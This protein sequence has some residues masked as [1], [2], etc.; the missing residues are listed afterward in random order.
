MNVDTDRNLYMCLIVGQQKMLKVIADIHR[1]IISEIPT[2]TSCTCIIP[3][4]VLIHVQ[5]FVQIIICSSLNAC[6]LYTHSG[7]NYAL[8]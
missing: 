2:V 6:E 4:V 8:L 7:S 1:K 5:G 3:Q